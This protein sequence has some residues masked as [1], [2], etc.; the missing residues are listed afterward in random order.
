[1]CLRWLLLPASGIKTEKKRYD[2]ALDSVKV[3]ACTLKPHCGT[4]G[5]RCGKSIFFTA[6]IKGRVKASDDG[7]QQEQKYAVAEQ[8]QLFSEHLCVLLKNY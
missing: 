6:V 4:Y 5:L 2:A 7:G 3:R 1:M 8:T